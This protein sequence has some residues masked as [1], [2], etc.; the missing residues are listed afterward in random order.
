MKIA[1]A[2][3]RYGT[4]LLLL[5]LLPACAPKPETLAATATEV[6]FTLCTTWQ[7]SL[8]TRSRR[9]TLQTQTEIGNQYDDFIV[10]CEPLP[11][12]F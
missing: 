2:L 12:P 7:E 3:R 9:D 11:L 4:V 6:G 1:A 5:V 10:A 8:P